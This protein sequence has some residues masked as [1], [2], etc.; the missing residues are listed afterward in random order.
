MKS[1]KTYIESHQPL[2]WTVTK[3]HPNTSLIGNNSL[4]ISFVR[5]KLIMDAV[6]KYYSLGNT[7]LDVGVYPGIVPQLFHE[8]YPGSGNYQSYYGLGLR[9]DEI[10]SNQ[11]KRIYKALL[12][13]SSK[14]VLHFDKVIKRIINEKI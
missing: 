8:Y 4:A 11:K 13:S 9:F 5:F 7:V 12:N 1:L 3:D 10:F 6:K 14:E 2:P